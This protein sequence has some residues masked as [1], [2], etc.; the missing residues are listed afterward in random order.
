MQKFA[1][2]ICAAVAAIFSSCSETKYVPEGSYLLDKVE[3]AVEGN[4]A[5]VNTSKMK[6]YVVQRG[7]S[8]WL[9]AAKLPLA[10]YS[11]S[12][13]DS[14]KWLNRTL[15]SMGEAPAIYDSAMSV[16][17]CL[18][19]TQQL[20]NDGFLQAST[21]LQTTTHKRKISA[22]YTLHPGRPYRIGNVKYAVADS[23]VA[24]LPVIADVDR[25]LIKQGEQFKVAT[26]EQ[27]RERITTMLNS[28]GYYKF[29]KDYITFEADTVSG[30]QTVDVTLVLHP[31][32]T[33]N[34]RQAQHPCYTIGDIKYGVANDNKLNI[35]RRVLKENT[36]IESGDKYSNAKL[37]RT[38]NSF[39]RLQAV[40]Y[41]DI[42][43][44]ES[45]A[46]SLTLDCD[47][48]LNTNKQHSVSIQPEGTNT[49]GDLGA[50]LAVTYENRNLFHGSELLSIEL[51]G[52]YEAIRGLEGYNNSDFEEYSAQASLTFPRFIAPFLPYGFRRRVNATSEVSM[53]YDLQNRPE[54]HRR[55]MSVAWRYKWN[56]A[57]HHDKYQV[58]LLDLNYVFMP[59]IS[60]TFRKNYLEDNASRNAILR[61]NYEDLF[62]MKIGFRY[63]YNNGR[64]AVKA[65]VETA[66]N[67][68][69]ACSGLFNYKTDDQGRRTLFNI[70]YAQYVKADLDYTRY[71]MLDYNNQ[72][73]F[74]CGLGVAYP[75]GN[76]DILPFEKRYFSGGAN[77]V[78]GWSVRELGPGKY[79]GH[80]GNIDFINQTGDVKLDLN[81]EY[82]AQLFWKFNGALFVDAGNIWT[83]RNYSDQP[84][85]QFKLHSFWRE[86][87]ASYGIGLRLNFDYFILRFD[88]AM[89]A[90]NPAY[91][92]SR[93]HYPIAHPD[94]GRDFTFHFAVGLPF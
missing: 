56:D 12:G 79:K 66:G 61:Y 6:Q 67:L 51:R 8:R 43:F 64:Y 70:A 30:Q 1:T 40:K 18:N 11:L 9:A 59:W 45:A 78:R 38:Y 31:F 23:D 32:L 58:D 84:D 60:D 44:K 68:L 37:K 24:A 20:R 74:H 53:L 77:S 34:K 72:F 26:L 83:L 75:Y 13:R 85:G 63:T 73:V 27:E 42:K 41:T 7:N 81:L 49:A 55:V 86:I 22:T 47:I 29:N 48:R 88:A 35:R 80:D 76:S 16:R 28:I 2:F 87:A 33:A 14:T 57:N 21:S 5:G 91:S 93:S 3:V 62:I 17:S 54:Y 65:N 39:G 4:A 36:F 92:D 15:K 25:R 94:F 90:I 10:T 50:A 52:A 69:D 89:K 46:D 19:L 82:R 71:V